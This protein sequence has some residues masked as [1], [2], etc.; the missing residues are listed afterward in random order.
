MTLAGRGF[1][2][3]F[4]RYVIEID[5]VLLPKTSEDHQAEQ[6]KRAAA[7]TEDPANAMV[8][9]Y[10]RFLEEQGDVDGHC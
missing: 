1:E 4:D 8:A 5:G 2:E 6:I 3:N 7:F 9:R 10:D